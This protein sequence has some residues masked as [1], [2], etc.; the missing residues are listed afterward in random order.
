MLQS[1]DLNQ[2]IMKSQGK[3]FENYSEGKIQEG[4]GR[5]TRQGHQLKDSRGED[6]YCWQ[7]EGCSLGTEIWD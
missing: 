3:M 7:P 1:T 2:I 5:G 4:I 6:R